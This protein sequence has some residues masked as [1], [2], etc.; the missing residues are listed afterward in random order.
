MQWL[1]ETSQAEKHDWNFAGLNFFRQR[2]QWKAVKGVDSENAPYLPIR[3][4]PGSGAT[5]TFGLPCRGRVVSQK[6]INLDLNI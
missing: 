3:P 6:K 1:R 5:M 2:G 4:Y